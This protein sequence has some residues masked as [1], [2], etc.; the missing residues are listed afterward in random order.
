MVKQFAVA[1]CMTALVSDVQWESGAQAI[2]K[3]L[4]RRQVKLW[5]S[6]L[7]PQL[8]TFKL[9]ILSTPPGRHGRY[10]LQDTRDSGNHLNESK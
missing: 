4:H 10:Q 3:H 6:P 8:K 7:L 2:V 5:Y 1:H 9:T